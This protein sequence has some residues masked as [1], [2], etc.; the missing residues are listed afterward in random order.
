MGPIPSGTGS[1][2]PSSRCMWAPLPRGARRGDD[3]GSG[4]GGRRVPACRRAARA[5]GVAGRAAMG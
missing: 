5:R 4:R 3:G 1:A 2:R